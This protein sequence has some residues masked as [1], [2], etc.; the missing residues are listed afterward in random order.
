[1]LFNSVLPPETVSGA[2]R[3]ILTA[4]DHLLIEG[5]CG[6]VSYSDACLMLRA[7]QGLITCHGKNLILTRL[8]ADDAVVTGTIQSLEIKP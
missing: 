4:T 7:K 8:S 6:L 5:H 2:P 1:M 3:I